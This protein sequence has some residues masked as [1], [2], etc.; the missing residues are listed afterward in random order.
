MIE[1]DKKVDPNKIVRQLGKRYKLVPY[2]EKAIAQFDEEWRYHQVPKEEDHHWHPSSH[3]TESVSVLYDIATGQ[4]ERGSPFPKKL[5]EVG[6]FWHQWLQHI[7]VKE[8]WCKQEDVERRG[9]IDWSEGHEVARVGVTEG[10]LSAVDWKPAPFHSVAGSADACPI[11]IPDWEG[12]VDYKTMN[13]NLFKQEGFNDFYGTKYECQMNMYMAMF[14]REEWM[15]LAID[16]ASGE[17]KEYLY[18]RNQPLI[19]AILEKWKFVSLCLDTGEEPTAEDD[20][21]FVLPEMMGY[22]K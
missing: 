2:L 10:G 22:V 8:G 4:H 19:D 14:E 11:V 15:I 9:M 20:A 6:N 16:K 5:A 12:G 13:P 3:C 7:T 21:M 1:L 17:F 18:A